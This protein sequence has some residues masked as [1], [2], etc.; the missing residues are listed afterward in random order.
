MENAYWLILVI[1]V[2]IVG[3]II[4]YFSLTSFRETID[5]VIV[6]IGGGLVVVGNIAFDLLLDLANLVVILTNV[7]VDV[8]TSIY[9]LIASSVSTIINAIVTVTNGIVDLVN[10]IIDAFTGFFSNIVD[11][12]I[13]FFN[14]SILGLYTI[15]LNFPAHATRQC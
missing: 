3:A 4:L 11:G 7:I 8:T 9:A 2:L 1:L 12:L 14:V 13:D 15:L 5:T 6:T 10:S